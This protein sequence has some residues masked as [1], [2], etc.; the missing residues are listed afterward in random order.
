MPCS[1]PKNIGNCSPLTHFEENLS[2][3]SKASLRLETS[4]FQLSEVNNLKP[5]GRS[6]SNNS[7]NNSTCELALMHASGPNSVP[8]L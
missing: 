7:S 6:S 4:L 3:L 2:I 1:P 5:Q 8:S